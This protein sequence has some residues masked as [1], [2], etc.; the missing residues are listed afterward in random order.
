[1][2]EGSPTVLIED[3]RLDTGALNRE[4]LLASDVVTSL[5]RQGADHM[6]D[7]KQAVL[8]PGG[9]IVVELI[10]MAMLEAVDHLDGV[11]HLGDYT[12]SRIQPDRSSD[13]DE[14]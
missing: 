8:A 14:G 11:R 5:R 7:V 2:F 4:G 12:S 1:L 10:P 9:N 6:E 3:G 13:S